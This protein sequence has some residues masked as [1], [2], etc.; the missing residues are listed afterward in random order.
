MRQTLKTTSVMYEMQKQVGL[1]KSI[2]MVS[3]KYISVKEAVKIMC[4]DN[5]GN[6]IMLSWNQ[7]IMKVTSL[8]A[9]MFIFQSCTT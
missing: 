1:N 6:E 2:N 9:G 4:N 3:R 7:I 8:C 5:S